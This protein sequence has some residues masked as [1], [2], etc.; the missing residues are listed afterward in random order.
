[1][2]NK[3]FLS[4]KNTN[5]DGT[6][7]E[8]SEIASRLYAALVA[9]NIPTF[10]SNVTL[11]EFGEV[12]YKDAIERALDE[13]DVLVL[14]GCSLNNITSRWVKYEWNSFH[15][16]ILSG[17][18]KN[19]VIVPYL[20][21][22]I[23]RK[24]RPIALRN[25]ETFCCDKD[26]VSK[27][28]EFIKNH[29]NRGQKSDFQEPKTR[30][31]GIHSSYNPTAHNE[32]R[33]LKIQ[34]ENTRAADMPAIY[35]AMDDLKGK[36]KINVL[37]LGCAYGYVTKDRFGEFDNVSVLGIDKQEA[38]IEY[39]KKYN[40]PDN[41][42]YAVVTVEDP[43]FQD[44]MERVME[45][46]GIESFD[47]I[48]ATLFIHH[49]NDP[50]KALRTVRKFLSP[51]GY[52]IVRGS[53][54]GSVIAY[55]DDGLVQKIIDKH[56]STPGISDRHNGRRLYFQLYTSGYKQI[57]M[58]NYVKEISTLDFDERMDVFDERFAY[59]RNYLKNMLDKDPGNM[60]YKNS[61]DWMDYALKK[62]ETLFGNDSFWYQEVDF[63]AVARKK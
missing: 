31:D 7:S 28:V 61:L 3:V 52:I 47:I 12:A 34:A 58:M 32:H 14:I 40:K 2:T 8:E 20:H 10:F 29:L 27:V 36:K 13:T 11:M 24:D 37:D 59:R 35:Y 53:D 16:E 17:D 15:E 5:A 38:C 55:N 54:D 57:K 18:K 44:E 50:I 49:L 23:E 63:V 46:N 33:R 4:F 43:S 21:S 41:F 42:N 39:A 30:D 62:L 9:E 56:L 19:G 45:E 6:R 48:I 1:M 51:D 25:Q 22:S 26:D 60:E